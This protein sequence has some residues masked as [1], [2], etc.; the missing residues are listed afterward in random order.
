MKLRL[1][2]SAFS[3]LSLIGCKEE[4]STAKTAAPSGQEKASEERPDLKSELERARISAE[5]A[6]AEFQKSAADLETLRGEERRLRFDLF[7]LEGER[8]DLAERL[9]DWETEKAKVAEVI[10][11]LQKRWDIEIEGVGDGCIAG[12]LIDVFRD[13]TGRLEMTLKENKELKEKLKAYESAP[14][15]R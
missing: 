9:R 11:D 6:E 13:T 8:R 3:M 1:L 15:T 14:G 4:G 7:V 5:N 12:P 10:V 2:L